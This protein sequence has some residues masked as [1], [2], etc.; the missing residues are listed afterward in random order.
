MGIP[1]AHW[2]SHVPGQRPAHAAP[3][4]E[5]GR[6]AE[7]AF[8]RPA[9]HLRNAGPAKRCGHQDRIWYAGA[10]FGRLHAGHLR[11]CNDLCQA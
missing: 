8:S 5:A 9:P 10:F 3:R 4:P 7:G 11:S 6:V 1:I 2:R